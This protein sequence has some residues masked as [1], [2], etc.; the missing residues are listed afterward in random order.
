M[1][2]VSP[3]AHLF[4]QTYLLYGDKL[5]EPPMVRLSYFIHTLYNVQ[6]KLSHTMNAV[7]RD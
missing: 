3:D 1:Y 4:R 2:N 5:D 6:R 7:H